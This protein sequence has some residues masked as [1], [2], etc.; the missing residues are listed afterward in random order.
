MPNLCQVIALDQQEQESG[1]ATSE[2]VSKLTTLPIERT[3][4]QMC[5]VENDIPDVFKE[6]IGSKEPEY[7]VQE[8]YHLYRLVGYP[9]V[10][11]SDGQEVGC[12]TLHHY[13]PRSLK[14]V[15]LPALP[16]LGLDYPIVYQSDN[17]QEVVKAYVKLS[18]DLP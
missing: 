15:A 17:G 1:Q 16:P 13:H 4:R 6:R 2:N 12:V 5:T 7:M 11:Q 14:Y 8:L 10:Y 18:T 9:I 3:F